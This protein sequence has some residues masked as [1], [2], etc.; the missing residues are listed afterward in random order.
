M[1]NH[2]HLIF[3]LLENNERI[4]KIMQYIKGGTAFECNKYLNRKGRFWQDESFD[5]LIRDDK[6]FYNILEY[7][8]NNPV[9]AGLVKNWEDWPYTFVNKFYL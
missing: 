3:R 9:K 6:E 2:I 1:P 5:R 7:V 4:D 8:K